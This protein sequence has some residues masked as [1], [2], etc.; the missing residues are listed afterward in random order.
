MSGKRS[1]RIALPPLGRTIDPVPIGVKGYDMQVDVVPRR[2]AK[3]E[4]PRRGVIPRLVLV[5]ALLQKAAKARDVLL[6]NDEAEVAL[7]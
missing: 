3:D 6:V 1:R 4:V 2:V 7:L 5:A